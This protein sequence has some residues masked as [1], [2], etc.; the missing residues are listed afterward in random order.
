MKE[1]GEIVNDFVDKFVQDYN[2]IRQERSGD[3]GSE[4]HHKYLENI[5]GNTSSIKSNAT[6]TTLKRLQQIPGHLL[7]LTNLKKIQH[8]CNQLHRQIRQ[9]LQ[10]SKDIEADNENGRWDKRLIIYVHST[11]SSIKCF[12]IGCN[13]SFHLKLN[14]FIIWKLFLWFRTKR[15][16]DTWFLAP[17]TKWCGSGNDAK[18]GYK[19]L[20]A[21]RGDTCCRKHDHCFYSIQGLRTKYGLFNV[22]PFS[23][24]HCRCDRRFEIE[25]T[26]H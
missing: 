9:K 6:F 4:K 3:F 17:N 11:R 5:N 16:T 25:N 21:S 23:I 2:F 19:E 22:R 18:S 1:G 26:S 20:G 15:H 24:S 7:E 14:F 10:E 12:L 13:L 8:R